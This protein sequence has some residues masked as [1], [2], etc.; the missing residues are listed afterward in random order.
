[1]CYTGVNIFDAEK[2]FRTSQFIVSELVILL[3]VFYIGLHMI[4]EVHRRKTIK[5]RICVPKEE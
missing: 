4:K 1:M 5:V 3:M 2:D